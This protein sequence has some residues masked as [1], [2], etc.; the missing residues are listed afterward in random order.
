[1][2]VNSVPSGTSR[3]AIVHD[4]LTGMRGG[5]KVLDAIC[6]LYPDATLHTLVRIPGSVSPRI[7]RRRV[8][9][10]VVQWLPDAGRL[11]RHY[12]PLFPTAVELIDLDGY[13]LVISSSHCAVKSVVRS[14]RATRRCGT[15]GISSQP[16]SD[17][18]R[19]GRC[20]AGCCGP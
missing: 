8:K 7:E 2:P 6:E 19:S 4:W 10:S 20:A 3:V 14:G 17:P 12:L 16:I 5:E 18:I 9:A 11:Y 15:R 13:D 1:M